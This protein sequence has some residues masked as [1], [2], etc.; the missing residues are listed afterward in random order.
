[1]RIN[2]PVALFLAQAT[3]YTVICVNFRAIAQ[4]DYGVAAT[5]EIAFAVINF[6]VIQK[7]AN[8]NSLKSLVAYVLGSLA[9]SMLGMYLSSVIQ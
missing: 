9:G 1:M 4:L 2:T 7:I 5:S 6:A 3:L 8:D